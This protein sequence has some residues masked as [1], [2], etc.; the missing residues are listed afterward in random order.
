MLAMK[1]SLKQIGDVL[2]QQSK[3]GIQ[4]PPKTGLIYK[5]SGRNIQASRVGEYAANRSGRLQKSINAKA[6]RE[7]LV[8]GSNVEYGK[9]LEEGH[10]SRSGKCVG[11]RDNLLKAIVETRFK[12]INI[13]EKEF[14]KE[15]KK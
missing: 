6:N 14:A 5:Y 10:K 2:V 15:L 11:K 4:N 1:N 9:F 7:R 13:V 12:Q 8:F 3:E